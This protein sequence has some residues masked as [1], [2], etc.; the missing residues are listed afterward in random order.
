MFDQKH[1]PHDPT[2]NEQLEI[3]FRD[4][5]YLAFLARLK[6]SSIVLLYDVKLGRTSEERFCP[7]LNARACIWIVGGIKLKFKSN[8]VH[9][10]DM[11][12]ILAI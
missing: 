5:I 3:E 1:K 4:K 2:K 7:L 6:I 12:K 11:S 8:L 10:L 9:Q